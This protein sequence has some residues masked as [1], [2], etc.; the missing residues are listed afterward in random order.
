[1]TFDSQKLL[2]QTGWRLLEA[3]QADARLSFAQLGRR[4]GL[5]PPAV[6]ER[7]R[8]ME[9]A[10]IITKYRAVVNPAKVGLSLRAIIALTTT[11]QQ[12]PQA[13]A[14]FKDLPAIQSCHHV[15]GNA[16]FWIEAI[17]PSIA[18]LENL[19]EQLSRFG[20]TS[21][22]IVLSSPIEKHTVTNTNRDA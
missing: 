16:S 17:S 9:E 13:I 6:A 1:M 14:L 8:R 7:V 11:P 20:T 21:T 10:G 22:S 15:T 2:D 4:V 12:Y 19:I 3:L 5:S 18:E